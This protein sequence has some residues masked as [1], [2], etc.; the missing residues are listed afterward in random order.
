MFNIYEDLLEVS[1]ALYQPRSVLVQLY[2]MVPFEKKSNLGSGDWSE[3]T[4]NPLLH[5]Q[6]SYHSAISYRSWK[7]T[8]LCQKKKNKDKVIAGFEKN[9]SFFFFGR[10]ERYSHE[11]F[12]FN[13]EKEQKPETQGKLLRNRLL[14]F[15][16]QRGPIFATSTYAPW[17]LADKFT[18]VVNSFVHFSHLNSRFKSHFTETHDSVA[19]ATN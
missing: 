16:H 2:N 1:A 5:S 3:L 14:I 6:D 7:S 12:K 15:P 8:A 10:S 19:Q 13:Q 17:W 9:N 18:I 11:A 4:W